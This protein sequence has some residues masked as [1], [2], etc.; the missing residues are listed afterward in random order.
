MGRLGN[1]PELRRLLRDAAWA[2]ALVVLLVSPLPEVILGHWLQISNDARP[3]TGRAHDRLD[4]LQESDSQAVS[5]STVMDQERAE[6]ARVATLSQMRQHLARRGELEMALAAFREFHDGLTQWQRD[7]I[8]S[9]DDLNQLLQRGLAY[10]EATRHGVRARF[11]FHD[12]SHNRLAGVELDLLQL[13]LLPLG[14]SEVS[15]ADT[16]RVLAESRAAPVAPPRAEADLAP[17]HRDALRQLRQL[18]G[19]ST[20]H[21]WAADGRLVLI[22]IDADGERR[23]LRPS[24]TDLSGAATGRGGGDA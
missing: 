23:W 18:P 2:A 20:R 12:E 7:Q 11:A 22:E 10:V 6:S 1:Q 13:Q 15:A 21:L 19:L 16:A 14:L 24:S 3:E 8:V 17:G 9:R 5:R 4:L